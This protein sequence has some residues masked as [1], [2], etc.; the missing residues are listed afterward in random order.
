MVSLISFKYE[1]F[2]STQLDVFKYCFLKP[3]IQLN[4]SDLSTQS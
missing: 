4:I 2:V 3:A 1:L